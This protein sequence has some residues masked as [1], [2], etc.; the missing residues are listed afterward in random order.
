MLDYP[1]KTVLNTNLTDWIF[2]L[3][4]LVLSISALWLAVYFYLRQQRDAQNEKYELIRKSQ[5]E[6]LNKLEVLTSQL[7]TLRNHL[8]SENSE[9]KQRVLLIE[10]TSTQ[11]RDKLLDTHSQIL[12]QL[13]GA[14]IRSFTENTELQKA[15]FNLKEEKQ[16]VIKSKRALEE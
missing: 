9:I 11:T 3:L 15:T 7:H 16:I 4:Q 13:M 5:R 1:R 14:T 6:L 2:F 12:D 10:D 8:D